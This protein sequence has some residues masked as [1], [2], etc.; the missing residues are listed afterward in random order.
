MRE[1]S[2]QEISTKLVRESSGSE[3]PKSEIFLAGEATGKHVAGAI[4]EAAI[5]WRNFY[6]LFMTDDIPQ[7][8]TLGIYLLDQNLGLID[9]A[10]LGA[11]YSTGSFSSLE[12]IPP[13]TIGFRF[14]GG[15]NWSVELLAKPVLRVPFISDPKGVSRKFGFDRH[16]KIH[17]S[18]QPER[19][20]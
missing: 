16:F 7:E 20:S 1:L 9:S 14:I 5:S 19:A 13:N 4:L 17:G 2:K 15:T 11:M 8:D 10:I 18:P 3:L 6:L 12:L